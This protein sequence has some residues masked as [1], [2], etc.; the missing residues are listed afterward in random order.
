MEF[1]KS[2]RAPYENFLR[3]K[4]EMWTGEVLV[5][6]HPY[7]L[8]LDPTSHCQLRCPS[9]PTGV[10][11]ASRKTGGTVR[12]RER[13]MLDAGVYDGL[14]D[15]LGDYLFLIMFY[16]WGEPLLN[17][18]LPALIRKAR[19]RDICAEIHSNLSLKLSD[20]YIE[21]LLTS[22]IDL[23]A[24]SI[25]GFSQETYETYRRG[26]RFETAKR[27]LERLVTKRDQLGLKT[28]II[29]NFLVFAFN[30]HEIEATR[31]YC[32]DIGATFNQREAFITDPDW[33][34]SYRK[35]ELDP[36][37]AAESPR[38]RVA[39]LAATGS[40]ACAWHYGYTAINANGTVS[41]CC[42]PWEQSHDFGVINAGV[43][44]F[45]GIWNNDHFRKSRAAFSGKTV[46]GLDQLTTICLECPYG[47]GIQHLYSGLDGNVVAQFR[48]ILRG[49]DA[50]L[51]RAFDLLPDPRAF[52]EFYRYALAGRAE[53]RTD[54]AELVKISL[55]DPSVA[56]RASAYEAMKSTLRPLYRGVLRRHP[57]LHRWA[58]NVDAVLKR[59]H[60]AR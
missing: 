54:G 53:G 51:D 31:R 41:P 12:F 14:L 19:A 37:A 39:G 10:E 27:N 29:W 47:S 52:V 4:Y 16:N 5:R 34:P 48:R 46:K 60:D 8:V 24:G 20:E 35:R 55:D 59:H 25:D 38:P 1:R 7:Y 26:G 57:A 43:S 6:S 17:R 40:S 42:A 50:A 28:E 22:G 44:S 11:N 58:K 9:C 21:D 18:N 32:E 56:R 15:E 13:T 2:H 49:T 36:P 45:A 30:E 3:S 23:I 33:L